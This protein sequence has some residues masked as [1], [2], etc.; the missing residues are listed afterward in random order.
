MSQR[1]AFIVLMLLLAIFPISHSTNAQ[2]IEPTI[3]IP[4][5][6]P[7]VLA[8]STTVP[9]TETSLP[10]TQEP[11]V[12]VPTLQQGS[13]E[14][15]QIVD[16]EGSQFNWGTDFGIPLAIESISVFLFG[17]IVWRFLVWRER[18]YERTQAAT[19]S[20]EA[21]RRY[22]KNILR[23]ID[24]NVQ[25]MEPTV[26]LHRIGINIKALEEFLDTDE[27]ER[28]KMINDFASTS[29]KIKIPSS[30]YWE[31]L[32]SSG[33]LPQLIDADLM[34]EIADFY[35]QLRIIKNS[36]KVP[37]MDKAIEWVL[38]ISMGLFSSVHWDILDA[39]Q[40]YL[41]E[42]IKEEST[43]AK[44]YDFIPSLYLAVAMGKSTSQKLADE[45]E[46]KVGVRSNS[47]LEHKMSDAFDIAADYVASAMKFSGVEIVGLNRKWTQT[48]EFGANSTDYICLQLNIS[49][50]PGWGKSITYYWAESFDYYASPTR[51]A[52]VIGNCLFFE[53]TEKEL[54]HYLPDIRACIIKMN[55]E[56]HKHFDDFQQLVKSAASKDTDRLDRLDDYI[57]NN[58]GI[59]KC[60]KDLRKSRFPRSSK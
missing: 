4:T 50:P 33:L 10:I 12:N 19:L 60:P 51:E 8:T 16:S 37:S 41:D 43:L 49:P 18:R 46:D 42:S 9:L 32:V 30:T 56:Y 7:D 29:P 47:R 28:R 44:Q 58:Q 57:R 40:L 6:T 53:G 31:A 2:D 11:T 14:N 5:S 54:K 36:T 38:T 20:D 55:Q 24:S 48:F 25:I 23:E 59:G 17:V 52:Y 35:Q 1:S 27:P 45:L 13:T 21:K 26:K 15:T 22:L 3:E 34:S 39:A